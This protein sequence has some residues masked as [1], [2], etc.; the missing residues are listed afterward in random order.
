MVLR[1]KVSYVK[2]WLKGV[3]FTIY[4]YLV[5]WSKFQFMKID[6]IA[7]FC[8]DLEQMRQFFIRHFEAQSNEQYINPRTGLHTYI[9]TFPNGDARLELMSRPDTI[10]EAEHRI[11]TRLVCRGQQGDRQCQDRGTAQCRIHRDKRP[12][13]HRR[14]LLWELHPRAGGLTDRGDGINITFLLERNEQINRFFL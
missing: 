6:H 8:K 13:H 2:Q 5:Y 7:L 11:H 3:L 9:L 10:F 1:K 12:T 4:S 14:R